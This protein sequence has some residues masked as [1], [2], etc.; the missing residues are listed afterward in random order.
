MTGATGGCLCKAV[1]YTARHDPLMVRMC[2]CRICQHVSGGNASVNAFFPSEDFAVEG[3]VRWYDSVADSGNVISRG[4][5]PTCGSPLFARNAARS[6]YLVVRA[7]SLDDPSAVSPMASIWTGEAPE[8]ALIHPDLPQVER[9][10]P[11]VA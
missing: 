9:Q 11:P 7:G 2:W 1:R 8:W 10:P 3:E 5:C 6:Q 4:F